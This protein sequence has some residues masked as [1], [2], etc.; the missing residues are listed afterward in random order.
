VDVTEWLCRRF[1]LLTGR[2]NVWLAFQLNLSVILYF[3][4]ARHLFPANRRGG[5]AHRRRHFL[6]R[7]PLRPFQTVFKIRRLVESEAFRRVARV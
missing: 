4:W 6:Q 2:T 5:R 7:R 3:V 1:Q